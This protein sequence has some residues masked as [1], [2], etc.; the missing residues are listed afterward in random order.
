MSALW[1]VAYVV[2]Y[3]SPLLI[4]TLLY[5]PLLSFPLF[6]SPYSSLLSFPLFLSPYSSLL[7]CPLFLSPYSSLLSS[8]HH[9]DNLAKKFVDM[10]KEHVNNYKAIIK[11]FIKEHDHGE[12]S[13]ANMG[14]VLFYLRDGDLNWTCGDLL[15]AVESTCAHHSSNID[16]ILRYLTGCYYN[17]NYT[18]NVLLC[19]YLLKIKMG[20]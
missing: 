20:I 19:L 2:L 5:S 16:T 18:C 8:S 14:G 9:S 12:P 11:D 7:S 4:S 10:K 6:L 13:T 15:E 17:N 3:L 1:L